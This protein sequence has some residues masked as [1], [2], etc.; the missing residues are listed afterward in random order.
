MIR[1]LLLAAV[2]LGP[3]ATLAPGCSSAETTPDV[4]AQDPSPR[5]LDPAPQAP[6]VDSPPFGSPRPKIAPEAALAA[7]GKERETIR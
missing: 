6:P 7:G 5:A 3:L 4:T 2:L 1:R